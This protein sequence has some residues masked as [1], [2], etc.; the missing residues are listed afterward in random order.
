[1]QSL[2]EIKNNQIVVSSRQIASNFGK[3]H[4]DVL[5]TIESLLGQRKIAPIFF[6][7]GHYLIHMEETRNVFL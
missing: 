5:R 7:R 3:L 4:K 6:M 1:M 2:V